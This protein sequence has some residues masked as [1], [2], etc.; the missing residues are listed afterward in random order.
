MKNPN[1]FQG[2]KR[3]NNYFEG[4]YLKHQKGDQMFSVI[5][6][7]HIDREGNAFSSLQVITKE[8]SWYFSWKAEAFCGSKQKFHVVLDTGRGEGPASIFSERGILLN[9]HE[10]GLSLEGRIIYKNIHPLSSDIMGPFRYVP[11]MQCRHGIISMRHQL[12]GELTLNGYKM[13]FD[14]GTGYIEKDWGGSFPD[15]YLWSQSIFPDSGKNSLMLAAAKIPIAGLHFDGVLA[16]LHLY[17]KEYK[18]GTYLGA[19]V[20]T[21]WKS[22]IIIRQGDLKLRAQLLSGEGNELLAPEHEAMDRRIRESLCCRV[23]YTFWDRKLKVLDMI[24]DR[25]SFEQSIKEKS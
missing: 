22:R 25:G 4:W 3:K 7:Y 2:T 15:A 1:A 20:K 21:D 16:A 5:P 18:M 23:R 19:K 12:F 11:G 9:I 24:T 6:A 14:Q 10:E 13:N 8:Q 17:G